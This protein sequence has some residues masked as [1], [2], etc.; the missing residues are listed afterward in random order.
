MHVEITSPR[1]SFVS[2]RSKI[3]SDGRY[4]AVRHAIAASAPFI[5]HVAG[6]GEGGKEYQDVTSASRKARK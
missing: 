1:T 4:R 6:I 2:E 5:A 3:N